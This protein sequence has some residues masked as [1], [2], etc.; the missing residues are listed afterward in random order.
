MPAL[1]PV[2]LQECLS[3]DSRHSHRLRPQLLS[4]VRRRCICHRLCLKLLSR[5]PQQLHLHLREP[6]RVHQESAAEITSLPRRRRCHT[7]LHRQMPLGASLPRQGLRTH[8][9]IEPYTGP[10]R[11]WRLRSRSPRRLPS[12]PST[13]A[14]PLV[15]H[16]QGRMDPQMQPCLLHRLLH[17]M[18]CPKQVQT[19]ADSPVLPSPKRPRA[20]LGVRPRPSLSLAACTQ[21]SRHVQGLTREAGSSRTEASA[22]PRR[23]TLSSS[24][25]SRSVLA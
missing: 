1:T 23:T 4:R 7:K 13:T 16:A 10:Q 12:M 14:P 6:R 20:R 18:Q 8:S 11:R 9:C 21:S 19:A 25:S 15:L 3:Q 24:A 17:R 5:V 2:C 22:C